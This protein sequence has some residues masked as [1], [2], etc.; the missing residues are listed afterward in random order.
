[1]LPYHT[2]FLTTV[3]FFDIGHCITIV[4]SGIFIVTGNVVLPC[5]SCCYCNTMLLQIR[6]ILCFSKI[7]H[8]ITIVLLQWHHHVLD[9]LYHC[10]V[11]VFSLVQ[12][13]ILCFKHYAIEK[14]L[15]HH[16]AINVGCAY[17]II[18]CFIYHIPSRQNVM[19]ASLLSLCCD[20]SKPKGPKCPPPSFVQGIACWNP[21]R[22]SL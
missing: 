6:V 10:I 17:I 1:M 2:T 18:Q 14:L 15:M 7:Y 9:L 3:L 20:I 8:C 16:M 22:R 13:K 11:I 4:F 5:F 21:V 19:W 12:W